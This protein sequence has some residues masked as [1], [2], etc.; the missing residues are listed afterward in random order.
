MNSFTQYAFP[1]IYQFLFSCTTGEGNVN[2]VRRITGRFEMDGQYHYTMETQTCLTVPI[3]DGIDV[4]SATQWI[5]VTQIAI[6]SCLNIPNNQVNMNV[7]RLGGAY[8]AKISRCNPVA[9]ASALAAHLLNRPV[10]FVMSLEANMTAL[11]KRYGCISDY[12]VEVD[13]NG[14]ILKMQNNYVQDYGCS[15]NE[16][17]VS[18]SGEFFKNCYSTKGWVINGKE[19]ITDAASNTWCRAPG[20]TEGVAMIEHIMDH[21]AYSIGKEPTEVRLTNCPKISKMRSIMSEFLTSVGKILK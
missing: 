18:H 16:G 9:C 12:E 10:R 19:A 1:F 17:V 13:E 21:I 3:E 8:G 4:F 20:T 14:L 7:R 11:G 2:Q 6:A 5:D 15:L